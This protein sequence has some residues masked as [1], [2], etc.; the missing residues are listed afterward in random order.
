MRHN[1]GRLTYQRHDI[2]LMLFSFGLENTHKISESEAELKAITPKFISF[3]AMRKEPNGNARGVCTIPEK[4]QNCD[5]GVS[6]WHLPATL[7]SPFV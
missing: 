1:N 2:V 6:K 5:S 3:R 4:S 7:S